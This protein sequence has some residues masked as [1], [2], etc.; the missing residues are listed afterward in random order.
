M[1]CN[2]VQLP[3]IAYYTKYVSVSPIEQTK[4]IL[5]TPACSESTRANISK[6]LFWD[7]KEHL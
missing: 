7:K 1:K 6:N 2:T 4:R 3:G 5:R